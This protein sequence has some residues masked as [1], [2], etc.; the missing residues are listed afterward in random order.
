MT[1]NR[2]VIISPPWAVPCITKNLPTQSCNAQEH[3][4]S[5]YVNPRPSPWTRLI[6][7]PYLRV[8]CSDVAYEYFANVSFVNADKVRI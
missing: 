2:A 8:A 3:I 5:P 1:A 6:N 7:I 4:A